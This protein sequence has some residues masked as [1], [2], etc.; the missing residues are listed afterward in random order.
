ML[1]LENKVALIT[2]ASRGIG[3][4]IAI[5]FAQHGAA[6]ALSAR[7][8]AVEE[9]AAEL[10]A[11]GA[12][13]LARRADINDDAQV[14]D[15]IKAIRAEYGRLDVLVNNAGVLQQ[16]L[17][18]MV[19]LPATRQMFET[20]VL[21]L[22]NLTQYAVRLMAASSSPA[23][24]NMASIAGTQGINGAA[25][26]SA[27]KAA[28]GGFTIAAA[29]ELAAKKIRVNAIAPGFIDT[30]MTRSMTPEAFERNVRGIRLGRIGQPEDIANAAVFLAS[31]L[32]AY[33][34]GQVLGVDGGM[35]T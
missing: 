33:V 11:S 6:L 34:T 8:E 31:D 18:G 1:L 21:S 32:S 35:T 7:S 22:I 30:D 16:S 9:L 26:Y 19:A 13:V 17:L 25:A 23:I 5:A 14:K 10:R 2:G 29:K 15:L 12:R 24:V 4:A 20:N 28:V 27:T 3:R